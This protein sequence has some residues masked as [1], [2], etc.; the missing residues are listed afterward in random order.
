MKTIKIVMNRFMLP[1][2]VV[3]NEHEFYGTVF[4]STMVQ[5]EEEGLSQAAKLFLL[6]IAT[7]M[8]PNMINTKDT[9]YFKEVMGGTTESINSAAN[10]V[11]EKGYMLEKGG[12]Y[13]VRLDKRQNWDWAFGLS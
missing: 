10:E 12:L 2:D 6:T 4:R 9:S 7:S 1:Q 13:Y 8:R 11:L 3:I 5:W